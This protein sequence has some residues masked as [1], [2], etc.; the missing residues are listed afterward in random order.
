M[1]GFRETNHPNGRPNGDPAC[2]KAEAKT[3][4]MRRRALLQVDH[5]EIEKHAICDTD[6]E[7]REVECPE[8]SGHNHDYDA[9]NHECQAEHQ[10]IATA[11]MRADGTSAD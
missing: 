4:K 7:P 6:Q 1:E 11:E 2:H 3:T 8:G 9:Y 5:G 10:G